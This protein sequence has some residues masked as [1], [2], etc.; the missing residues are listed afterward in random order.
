[1]L[2]DRQ[3]HMVHSV[4]G[5]GGITFISSPFAMRPP[6]AITRSSASVS[7]VTTRSW[8][9][10]I[11]SGLPSRRSISS[12][13]EAR[14]PSWQF[15][16]KVSSDVERGI[17]TLEGGGYNDLDV[18]PGAYPVSLRVRQSPWGK[19]GRPAVPRG[20]ACSTSELRSNGRPTGH[21]RSNR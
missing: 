18:A 14:L 4:H 10:M 6:D 7:S 5:V 21:S 19:R 20:G 11:R 16:G 3:P 1:M 12:R 17:R 9:S 15:N 2:L 13:M 8:R